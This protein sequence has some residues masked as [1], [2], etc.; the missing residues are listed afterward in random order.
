MNDIH[1]VYKGHTCRDPW[2]EVSEYQGNAYEVGH[3]SLESA[4]AMQESDRANGWETAVYPND[5]YDGGLYQVESAYLSG[6]KGSAS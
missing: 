5:D 3:E 1:R 4:L 6:V 2:I